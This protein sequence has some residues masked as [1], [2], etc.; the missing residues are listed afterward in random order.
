M[1]SA[2][3]SL[4][5]WLKDKTWASSDAPL[6]SSSSSSSFS[7]SSVVEDSRRTGTDVSSFWFVWLH[8]PLQKATP[9]PLRR[10]ICLTAL[11]ITCPPHRS[12]DTALNSDPDSP[13]SSASTSP[14][15]LRLESGSSRCR[16]ILPV[17]S[18]AT[19]VAFPLTSVRTFS[20]NIPA[21]THTTINVIYA[22]VIF[23]AC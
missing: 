3:L 5:A 1:N 14:T 16:V 8:Y 23:F 20:T 4:T 21:K 17:R 11:S 9:S 19:K 15:C 7:S 12:Q 6:S 22:P 13:P 18:I 10:D 2:L